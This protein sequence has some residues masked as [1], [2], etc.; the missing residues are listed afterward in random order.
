VV[1][2]VASTPD[3]FHEAPDA[4]AVGRIYEELAAA[5]GCGG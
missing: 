4:E 3:R 5:I 2:A 1:R